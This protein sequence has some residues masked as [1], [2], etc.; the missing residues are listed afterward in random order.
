MFT[1]IA[2]NLLQLAFVLLLAPLFKGVQKWLEERLQGKVGPSIFQPWYDLR[3]LFGK[4]RVVSDQSSWIFCAAPYVAFVAPLVVTLLIPVLTTYPL[5]LAFMA[6]MVGVGFILALSGLFIAL[7]AVDT[8]N[9]YGAVGASRTR[10][11]GFLVEPIWMMIFFAISFRAYSTIPYFV[12]QAWA[13]SLAAFFAP[14]HILVVVALLMVVI[15]ETGGSPVDNPAGHFELAMIDES[16]NLEYSGSAAALMH[17]AGDM[18]LVV[19][20]VVLENVL[21]SPWGLASH[22]SF[23]AALAAVPWIVL[24]LLGGIVVLA[25]INVSFAK[26]RLFRVPEYLAGAFAVA[27]IALIVEVFLP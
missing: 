2:I 11:V 9:P 21:L 16:K 20:L 22:V 4:D 3:K 1:Y 13:G 8:A 26:L 17:W 7:A 25:V 23:L 12:Q 24:K 5:F 27:V 10:M 15:A 6:E 14:A 18:K 19:V